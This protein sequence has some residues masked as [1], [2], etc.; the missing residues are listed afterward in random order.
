MSRDLSWTEKSAC[1]G[2]TLPPLQLQCEVAGE[3]SKCKM[4]KQGES[5]SYVTLASL[6][7]KR[8]FMEICSVQ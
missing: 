1:V 5:R 7:A 3:S 4:R 6:A 8:Q 2:C